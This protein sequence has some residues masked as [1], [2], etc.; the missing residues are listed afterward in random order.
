MFRTKT[1]SNRILF[2]LLFLAL[3]CDLGSRFAGTPVMMADMASQTASCATQI[4]NGLITGN[5][6]TCDGMED[7]QNGVTTSATVRRVSRPKLQSLDRKLEL[8]EIP[9]IPNEEIIKKVDLAPLKDAE[10]KACVGEGEA[11]TQAKSAVTKAEEQNRK[12]SEQAE[13]LAQAKTKREAAIQARK[14]AVERN[15][16]E[17]SEIVYEIDVSTT[18][19]NASDC[20]QCVARMNQPTVIPATS[21]KDASNLVTA[22]QKARL[23]QVAEINQK[24]KE[25]KDKKLALDER[26]KRVENCTHKMEGDKDVKRTAVEQLRCQMDKG[27]TLDD[28]KQLAHFESKVRPE[29]RRL[30]EFGSDEERREAREFASEF[31]KSGNLRAIRETTNAMIVGSTYNEEMLKIAT[32]MNKLPPNDPRRQAFKTQLDGLKARIDYDMNMAANG[33]L[34]RS[35][36][37]AREAQSEYGYWAGSLKAA[38]DQVANYPSQFLDRHGYAGRQRLN[39]DLNMD[40]R[41]RR[42][43]PGDPLVTSTQDFQGLINSTNRYVRDAMNQMNQQISQI[44][45]NPVTAP[46]GTAPPQFTPGVGNSRFPAQPGTTSYPQAPAGSRIPTPGSPIRGG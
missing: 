16:K 44:T 35:G 12:A 11:C 41:Q 45:Q 1:N 21:V 29:L 33:A 42:G 25:S 17:N 30:L 32:E 36:M 27:E 3:A 28:D 20:P 6:A 43:L 31:A 2:A 7:S 34:S 37:A 8:A 18:A 14:E 15:S 40:L 46:V 10:K 39:L 19:T 22:I 5:E 23:D 13:R 9:A 26:K 24:K 4:E 38:A